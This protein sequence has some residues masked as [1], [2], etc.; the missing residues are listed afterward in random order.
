MNNLSL[1]LLGPFQATLDDKPITQF[2]TKS[3]QALL[4]FLACEAER[5]YPREQLM[6]LL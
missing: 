1:A 2:R 4:I 3:V 6:E 5:P